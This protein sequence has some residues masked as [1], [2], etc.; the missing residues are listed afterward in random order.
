VGRAGPGL[1]GAGDV[2]RDGRADLFLGAPYRGT[3]DP[4]RAYLIYGDTL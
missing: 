4:G 2:D 3:D 1:R